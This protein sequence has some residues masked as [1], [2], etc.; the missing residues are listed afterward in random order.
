MSAINYGQSVRVGSSGNPSDENRAR[1]Y[2]FFLQ[3]K[4]KN[5]LAVRRLIAEK[6]EVSLLTHEHT[7]THIDRHTQ[8]NECTANRGTHCPTHLV[9]QSGGH[10]LSPTESDGQVEEV[11][12][13]QLAVQALQLQVEVADYVA[14]QLQIDGR[15]DGPAASWEVIRYH[16]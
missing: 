11:E 7:S 2:F 13:W 1:R 10:V 4:K 16:V 8:R 14:R 15:L 5:C 9:V 12:V 3:I 6:T